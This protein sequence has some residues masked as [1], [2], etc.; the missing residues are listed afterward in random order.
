MM[1]IMADHFC[2]C[3]VTKC[4]RHPSSQNNGCD[5]CIKNNLEKK[6]MPACF[7]IAVN[8]DV[9]EVTDYSMKGFVEFFLKRFA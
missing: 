2:T 6:R 9:S 5:P 3:P 1:D 4:P 7:F 8:E